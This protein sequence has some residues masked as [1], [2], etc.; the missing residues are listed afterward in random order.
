MLG[1]A[2]DLAFYPVPDSGIWLGLNW[3]IMLASA[4]VP[5]VIVCCLIFRC[6]ESPRWY[7][8]K[9][10]HQDAYATLSKLRFN[11]VSAAR[12][13]FYM[14]TLLEA[15]KETMTIGKRARIKEFFTLRRNRNAIVASEIVMFMQQVSN[16]ATLVTVSA[17]RPRANCCSSAVST[18]LPTTLQKSSWMPDFRKSTP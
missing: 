6:P 2:A 13:L 18:L 9:G 15:E 3:R 14:H 11:K 5:A 7:L 1:F 10:R 12:D 16:Q 8:S 4:A 17:G